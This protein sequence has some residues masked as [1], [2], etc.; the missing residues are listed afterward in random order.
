M[1]I[2]RETTDDVSLVVILGYYE[3]S[4]FISDQVKS[5]VKQKYKNIKLHIF[6][7]SS[8]NPLVIDDL[9]LTRD[10][11]QML[12]IHNRQSNV[13]FS[14]N[15]LRALRRKYHG[16]KYFAFSDQDDIWDEDKLA[17]AVE[18]IETFQSD[19]PVLYCSRTESVD[20]AGNNMNVL[21]PLYKKSPS[22]SNALVQSIS[23]GNTMVFNRAARDL[24]VTFSEGHKI[25]SHDWWCYQVI[26][27]A[28]GIVY[29]DSTSHV[30][31]RQHE[32]NIVGSNVGVRA[33]IQR[34]FAVFRG[35][36]KLWNDVNLKALECNQAYLTEVN[37][38]RLL[39]FIEARRSMFFKRLF[40]AKRAGI[41]RQSFL[42]N[43][44]LLFALLFNKL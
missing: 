23:G 9:D 34:A 7:D 1:A 27:G 44:G 13:G 25:V 16:V 3:G 32:K 6:D 31:Y 43:C 19:I 37:Q 22:F 5:I 28:G 42:G 15:F 17:K 14:Q 36:F 4:D 38:T 11:M 24:I 10:Q 29:Y 35:R 8:R 40:L 33:G 12:K 41:H 30:K 2:E 20:S 18:V 26:S 21:S 39:D